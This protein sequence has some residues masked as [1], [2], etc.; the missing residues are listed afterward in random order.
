ML[1]INT[2]TN[3]GSLVE[4]AHQQ[5]GSPHKVT[6]TQQVQHLHVRQHDGSTT[7]LLL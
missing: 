2:Y 4:Q 6:R 1:N 7:P 3:T 5:E